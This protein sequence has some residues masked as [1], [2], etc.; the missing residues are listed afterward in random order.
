MNGIKKDTT[1]ISITVE[2]YKRF[3]DDIR[4]RGSRVYLNGSRE[5][6]EVTGLREFSDGPWVVCGKANAGFGLSFCVRWDTKL[7]LE[8]QR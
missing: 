6:L 4:R 5:R 1:S 7:E 8:D 2:E 3:A